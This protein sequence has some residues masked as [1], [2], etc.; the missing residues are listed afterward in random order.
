MFYF[1]YLCVI[2]NKLMKIQLEY[3]YD[4]Y[5]GYL[6]TNSEN[7]KN[8]CLVHKTNYSR[9]TI[10]YAR[11]LMSV[12]EKRKLLPEEQVDHIDEDKT[13]DIIY[14]LQILSKADNNRKSFIVRNKTR[15][16]VQLVC[17][18]CNIIFERCLNNTHLQKKGHYTSCS[19]KCSYE[20]L[21][22][23]LTILELKNLGDNQI[24]KYYRK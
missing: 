19:R 5:N 23:K 8:I 3:P 13:N 11:Y 1:L 2:K 20:I 14:N 17:P 4:D 10:S 12:K 16:M 7:R 9:T 18:N 22:K 6:V 24:I 15:K 21:S